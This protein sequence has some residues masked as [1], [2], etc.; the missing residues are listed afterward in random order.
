M[1]DLKQPFGLFL[2]QLGAPLLGLGGFRTVGVADQEIVKCCN[3]LVG[4]VLVVFRPLGFCFIG[5]PD[6][7][8]GILRERVLGVALQQ[9]FVG[10][11]RSDIIFFF[12]VGQ[13]DPKLSGRAEFAVG[14][15]LDDLFEDF[16]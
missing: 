13:A 3:S 14:A 7:E 2:F 10:V 11:H 16:D 6:L 5:P 1:G 12:F 9:F 4:V 15:I 8:L